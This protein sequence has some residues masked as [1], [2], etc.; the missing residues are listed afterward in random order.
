MFYVDMFK[1]SRETDQ[2]LV[3]I[4]LNLISS[5]EQKLSVSKIMIR[6]NNQ[7][8]EAEK[9]SETSRHQQEAELL[10]GNQKSNRKS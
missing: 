4:S 8:P 7:K 6:I 2:L 9:R 3:S 5:Q 1:L 10:T